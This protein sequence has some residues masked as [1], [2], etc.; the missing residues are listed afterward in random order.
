[1]LTGTPSE[2]GGE[3]D[4]LERTEA[5]TGRRR[6]AEKAKSKSGGFEGMDLLPEVFRAIKRKG[7]RIP[8]AH[9]AEGHFVAFVRARTW[10]PWPEPAPV[11]LRRSSFPSCTSFVS[12]RSRLARR[13]LPH[14]RAYK[15]QTF[16]F[17]SSFPS[18]TSGLTSAVHR[19]RRL[20]GGAVR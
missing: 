10:S 2:T 3:I 5:L 8:D 20:H 7:Y 9:P 11:R 14:A 15:M 13:R 17:A 12:T 1:M 16:K 4:W 18:S 19:R 6:K